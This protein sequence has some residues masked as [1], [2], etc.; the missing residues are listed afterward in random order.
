MLCSANIITATLGLV[1]HLPVCQR[2]PV[3]RS[4]PFPVA[5]IKKLIPWNSP[6]TKKLVVIQHV[7]KYFMEPQGSLKQEPATEAYSEPDETSSYLHIP[8]YMRSF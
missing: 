3:I 1:L 5:N 6:T 7:K 4:F 2:S 8:T